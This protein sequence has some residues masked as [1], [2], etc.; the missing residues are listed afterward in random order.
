MAKIVTMT[1]DPETGD[2]E[3]ETDGYRG[4]GCSAVQDIFTKALGGETKK[5]VRKS[6]FNAPVTKTACQTR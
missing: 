5:T 1:I 2:A 4:R 6:E 3:V